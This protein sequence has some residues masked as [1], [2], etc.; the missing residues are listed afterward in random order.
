M[1]ASVRATLP[2]VAGSSRS[3][4]KAHSSRL[5]VALVSHSSSVHSGV[6]SRVWTA[7]RRVRELT[8]SVP[9]SMW[10]SKP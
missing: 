10:T 1:A 4:A 5:R 6:S 7:T 8:P 2:I 9:V 3:M